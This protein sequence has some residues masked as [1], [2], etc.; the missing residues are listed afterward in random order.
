MAETARVV[1]AVRS[2]ALRS[3]TSEASEVAPPRVE[4]PEETNLY[5]ST[6]E[7]AQEAGADLPERIGEY[8][9]V[10]RLGKPSGQAE[11]YRAVHPRL[12]KE[13]A[14][15]WSRRQVPEQA[16]RDRL[17]V[18]ARLLATL[19]HPGLVRVHDVG[20]HEGR[21]FVVMEYVPGRDLVEHSRQVRSE[22]REAAR[23]VAEIARTLE[24]IHRHG[25]VHQDLK[26]Q[27]V[28]MDPA[29]RTRLI[30][31]GLARLR[32]YWSSEPGAEESI[33]GTP[34][35]M[36]PEQARGEPATERS[37]VFAL[38]AMLYWLLT[39]KAPFA[40]A[41]PLESLDRAARCD[42]DRSA[43]KASHI[44]RRLA[45]VCERAM[46]ADPADRFGSAAELADCLERLL[47]RPMLRAWA[48]SIAAVLLLAITAWQLAS[49]VRLGG[50]ETARRASDTGSAVTVA[51]RHQT[52]PRIRVL[53]GEREYELTEVLPL[54]S[55]DYLNVQ[56]QV[57]KGWH[58]A[59]CWLDSEG[60]TWLFQMKPAATDSDAPGGSQ[61]VVWP[62]P[63]RSQELAGAPGTE[64]IVLCARRDRAPQL[65]DLAGPMLGGKPWPELPRE[66]ALLIDP[67]GEPP[68]QL[69]S[70]RGPGTARRRRPVKSLYQQAEALRRHLRK[71]VDRFA[72]IAFPHAP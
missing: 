14:I 37:D 55:G 66:A 7:A 15:K 34:A 65:A 28:I 42:W 72:A 61:L 63:D 2:V 12:P 25:I 71:R 35:Y 6:V 10:G 39:G 27:N 24:Y 44:P 31:F 18:E 68:I 17:M 51:R 46:A 13:V 69:V 50:V 4:P 64:L 1:R 40:A 57:P 43:L 16:D 29:G 32:D 23:L 49:K 45:A 21:L 70:P 53:R 8:R 26:P 58:A 54:R 38:G 62:E 20:V 59:L 67:G 11:V 9:I 48:I 56:W 52:G 3:Q 60:K 19:D 36:A 30:D 41:K 5:K 47:R 22:P 33:S